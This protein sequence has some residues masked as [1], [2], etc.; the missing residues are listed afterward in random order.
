[1][2]YCPVYKKCGGCAYI[3]T[4]YADQLKNKKE[5][6]QSL[7]PKN[8][9]EPVIGMKEPYHYRHKIYATFSHNRDGVIKC[10][11]YEENTH[12]VI[13][14]KMCLIQHVKAN[15]IL[16]DMC[17]I[18][19]KMHIESYNEDTGRGV[20][21]HAYIR[22]SHATND[23]L[24][25]IVIGSKNL[26]GSNAFVKEMVRMH[27][28]IKSIVLNHNS[29]DTSMVLGKK[30]HVLYGKGFIEDEIM[31]TRF[32]ISTNTFYQV[33]P[34]QTEKIYSTAIQM[35]QLKSTDT[36]LDM[37]CGIG[38]ISLIAAKKASFVLGVE[39]NEDSI[40]DAIGNAKRNGIKNA[41][42]IACD[43][44][45]FIEQLEDSPNV[46]FLDPPRNG[47]T[48]KFMKQLDH[49]KSDKIVYISC[50]PSTQARDIAFLKHYQIKKIVPVDN[51]PFTKHVETVVLLS[52]KKPDG[53]INV[54]VEFGEG[55]GK[56]PLDNIA[57]RAEEYKP[58]ERVTYKMIKEYIE[59]KYG[60]KVHTAYIAEVKRDLGLP[61][62][63]APN[64]VEEL[65]QPRKHPTAEKVEA[66]K[67]AL[68]YFEIMEE[69]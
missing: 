36:V 26:P 54:K 6:I 5:Y 34:V 59:A 45:E 3:N 37:C 8:N 22:I 41:Q 11:M 57:K 20:L 53:H 46:V 33:N 18:A 65:K 66:I 19:T 28:E 39:I 14:T 42:F 49:L 30:N 60:F 17:S 67:D 9:V 27:P 21:R 31:H 63:D 2:K 40:R 61:M 48:E 10:G 64:A 29:D 55:E 1:M 68:R 12:K 47:F 58:K 35:A 56:V 50:N 16:R 69:I 38:T 15:D 25:T 4:E 62:Y 52:H 13:D 51:F 44:E 23:V 32:R 24:L 7:F 43:S